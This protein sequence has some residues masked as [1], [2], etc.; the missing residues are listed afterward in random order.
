MKRLSSFG[1]SLIVGGVARVPVLRH[2]PWPSHA[3]VYYGMGELLAASGT[4]FVYARFLLVDGL[5]HFYFVK[6]FS[7]LDEAMEFESSYLT[8][9]NGDSLQGFF[10]QW[11][12]Y[13]ARPMVFDTCLD[14]QTADWAAAH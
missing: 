13:V 4:W 14:Y 9:V 8:F 3:A 6:G 11:F 10:G 1:K 2:D 12:N 7:T 5:F